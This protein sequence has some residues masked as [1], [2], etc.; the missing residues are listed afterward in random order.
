MGSDSPSALFQLPGDIGTCVL[1]R[2]RLG[3][4]GS[5]GENL[6]GVGVSR[7]RA[8]AIPLRWE[9]NA[10]LPAT[11]KKEAE[12]ESNAYGEESEKESAIHGVAPHM[13]D[14]KA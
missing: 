4:T 3:R 2:G 6:A 14:R 5:I 8:C 13:K 1:V 9:V 11:R 12:D 7:T 10:V